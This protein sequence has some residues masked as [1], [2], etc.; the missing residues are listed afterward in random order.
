MRF[1]ICIINNNLH[2]VNLEILNWFYTYSIFL[3]T[4]I[5]SIWINYWFITSINYC[6]RKLFYKWIVN[7]LSKYNLYGVGC[8]LNCMLL[9]NYKLQLL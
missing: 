6:F 2:Y 9:Y 5:V 7:K 3:M 8:Y 1:A 4:K